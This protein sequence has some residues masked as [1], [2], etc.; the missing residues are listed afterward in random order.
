MPRLFLTGLL[1]FLL[2]F[3]GA[4]CETEKKAETVEVQFTDAQGVALSPKLE[5]ELAL[6]PAQQQMGLMYRQEMADERGM[7][8]V[9]AHEEP[10]SFW[11]KNTYLKLDIVYLDKNFRVVSIVENATPHST[12]PRPSGLPTKY[13]VEVNG[14]LTS[15]WGVKKGAILNAP[16]L[17]GS[18]L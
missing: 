14:G 15:K 9:F 13:V 7:L 16:E 3:A 6:T 5:V 2:L 12:K 10:R 11:M 8:F 17:P 4:G 18:N 1:S